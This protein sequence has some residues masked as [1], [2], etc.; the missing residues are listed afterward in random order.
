MNSWKS[1]AFS[2]C[3]PPLIDVH[4]RHGQ[5]VRARRRRASGRA[6]T[7]A[8]RGRRLRGRQR[9]AEDRV[10]AEPALVRRAV[11]LDQRRSSAAWSAA[12]SPRT[13]AA[14]SPLDVRDR[15]RD[16]LAAPRGAAVAQLD[17]LVHA[18]RGAR[19]H[20]RPADGAALE[21]DVDLDRRVAARVEDLAGV[22]GGDG[23]HRSQALLGE[24]EVAVLLVERQG[25]PVLALA[26]RR[27]RSAS[28]T[29]ARNRAVARAELEL[30]IG[31]RAAARR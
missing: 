2:A 14:I 8:S 30:G 26:R 11:E 15:L 9:D 12:S 3:A 22:D 27:S 29:R 23:W 18:G 24:V 19:G 5:D 1:I 21:R 20:G 6:A 4:H 31:V 13:A 7:P 28:S 25:G 17:R 10:R 16:A